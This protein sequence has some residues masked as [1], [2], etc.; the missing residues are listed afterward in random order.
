MFKLIEIER[1][2][3]LLRF[4]SLDRT[5]IAEVFS[6]HLQECREEHYLDFSKLSLGDFEGLIFDLHNDNFFE[7]VEEYGI[8]LVSIDNQKVSI[9]GYAY[10]N[11]YYSDK[12]TLVI[13]IK[14]YNGQNC[15]VITKEY[16][17]TSCQYNRYVDW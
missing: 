6:D 16:D 12:L 7:R 10:N 17:I 9:P 11:G 15:E 2:N 14:K 8:R 5:E 4:E 13:R 3:D 1:Q